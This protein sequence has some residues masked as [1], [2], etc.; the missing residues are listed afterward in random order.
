M[1]ETETKKQEGVGG[2]MK[3]T[4]GTKKWGGDEPE[5]S[6]PFCPLL[7]FPDG[8]IIVFAERQL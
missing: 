3:L 6:E 7:H 8:I 4:P 5:A 1:A 2:C